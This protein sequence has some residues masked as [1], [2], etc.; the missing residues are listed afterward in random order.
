MV[1]DPKTGEVKTNAQEEIQKALQAEV[2]GKNETRI[3][4]KVRG[5][6]YAL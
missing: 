5:L 3:S 6:A 1:L 4:K 2:G